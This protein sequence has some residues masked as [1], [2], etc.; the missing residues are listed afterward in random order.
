MSQLGTFSFLLPTRIEFG[1]GVSNLIGREIEA[2][3][4]KR[5]LVIT[6]RGVRNT[7]LVDKILGDILKTGA[8]VEVF[9]GIE[10][11]PRDT[12]IQAATDLARRFETE[13]LVAV[14][15]GSPIDAAKGVG[16]LLSHGRTLRDYEGLGRVPGPIKPVIAI[17]TTAG[18]GS[19]VT[20][21]AVITDT[22]RKLKMSIGSSHIA[23]VAALVDPELTLSLPPSLTAFTGMDALTHA[24]EALTA[25]VSNPV[26]DALAI[27]AIELISGHLRQ[28]TAHGDDLN[29]R[30]AMLVGSLLAGLA[31]GNSD[32]GAVHCMAEALGGMYDTPHGLAN[33]IFLA[34]VMQFNAIAA[35]DKYARV[36]AAMGEDTT[37]LPLETAADLAVKAVQRL[38]CDLS[39]P[40]LREV[41]VREEDL[42]ELAERAANNVSVESNA[43]PISKEEFLF[44]FR[45]AF[46]A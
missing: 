45:K 8:S 24:I 13:L 37:G 15:G 38:S 9:D 16:L 44:L 7:G 1:P 39:I 30:A 21:W 11:N 5:V 12:T 10:P 14:G 25:R 29:A 34:E 6:D 18:T 22:Q 27:A 19:E 35:P 33:A 26:T 17:P 46:M 42:E 4:A 2:L 31:F 40:K 36:A 3:G 23:P 43:R 28:A 41:G 20:F 32:V